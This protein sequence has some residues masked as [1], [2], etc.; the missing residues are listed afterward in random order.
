MSARVGSGRILRPWPEVT[1]QA[2]LV[3][4]RGFAPRP[5]VGSALTL[6]AAC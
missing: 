1:Q 2:M 4:E 5:Y 3:G 6:L